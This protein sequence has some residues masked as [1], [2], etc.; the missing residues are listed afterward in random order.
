MSDV[1]VLYGNYKFVCRENK[2]HNSI[3]IEVYKFDRFCNYLIG[4][5]IFVDKMFKDKDITLGMLV[6]LL[7]KLNEGDEDE[8]DE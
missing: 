6:E 1:Q 7:D 8:E 5:E 3:Y 2:K 4:K